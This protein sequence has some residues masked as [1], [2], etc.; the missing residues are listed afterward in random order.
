VNLKANT[1]STVS[2]LHSNWDGG[3]ECWAVNTDLDTVGT[4][5]AAGLRGTL[6]FPGF[7]GTRPKPESALEKEEKRR[8]AE[9][10][11]NK[12]KA[13]KK[14]EKQA[15]EKAEEERK[16]K[17][18]Q[19]RKALTLDS[20]DAVADLR[21]GLKREFGKTFVGAS[22]VVLGCYRKISY[23][24]RVCTVYFEGGPRFHAGHP[25]SW[26]DHRWTFKG[27]ARV[28]LRRQHGSIYW[29]YS[30][31]LKRIDQKCALARSTK[32][33]TKKLVLK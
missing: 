21:L 11:A 7:P 18:R 13:Q 28:W 1:R 8:A 17:A 16:R 30:W 22:S 12:E 25:V 3:C 20:A 9:A 32:A 2:N 29:F 33:C 4:V 27:N 6:W 19:E 26:F 14:K 10:Q 23:D 5:A 15:R 24:K 31:G